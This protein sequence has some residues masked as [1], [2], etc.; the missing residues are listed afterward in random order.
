VSGTAVQTGAVARGN[1]RARSPRSLVLMQIGELAR[2][3]VL[4]VARQPA[5]VIPAVAFPLVL[6]AINSSGLSEATK[7]PGFPTDSYITF[8]LSFAF[9]QGAMFG[10][11]ITGASLGEDNQTGF[12]NR[13]RL[14]SVQPFALLAGQLGGVLALALVQ[15]VVFLGVGFAGGAHVAAGVGGVFVLFALTTLIC[16]AFGSIGIFAGVRSRSPEAVMGLFPVMFVFLFLSSMSMPRNLIANDWFRMVATFNPAS[17]L[18]EGVRSLL[19]YGWDAEALL[20]GFGFAI[21]ILAL[22]I[23]AASVALRDRMANV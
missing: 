20:L 14:S 6:L 9:I 23:Y 19:V 13:L 8:A 15:A 2:R 12:F 16:L 5:S 22:G 3:S 7:I 4:R 17:Y 18:V 1:T 10:V 11:M 21:A